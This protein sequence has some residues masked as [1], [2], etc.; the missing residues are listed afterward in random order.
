MT[1]TNQQFL[2]MILSEYNQALLNGK[3]HEIAF[4]IATN[5]AQK[6]INAAEQGEQMSLKELASKSISLLALIDLEGDSIERIMSVVQKNQ[7]YFGVKPGGSTLE[8]AAN[9][10]EQLTKDAAQPLRAVDGG[11]AG[12]FEGDRE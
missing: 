2:A 10:L 9:K 11:D 7:K 3:G 4:V 1:N 8:A 5:E 12:E 6:Y